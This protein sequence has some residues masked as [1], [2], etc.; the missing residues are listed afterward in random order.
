MTV[1]AALLAPARMCSCIQTAAGFRMLMSPALHATTSMP[2]QLYSDGCRFPCDGVCSAS[3]PKV[4][5]LEFAG[6]WLAARCNK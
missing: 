5:N 6:L 2:Q 4:V 3:A 1:F